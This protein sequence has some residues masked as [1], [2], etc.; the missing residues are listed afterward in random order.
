MTAAMRSLQRDGVTLAYV[1]EGRGAP[2]LLLVHGWVGDHTYLA[3]QF[4]RFQADHRVV[5]V[6]LRGHGA[7]DRPQPAQP[8]TIAGFADDLAW[9]CD[10]LALTAPVVV[11]HS[12]G[13]VV[14]L[15]LAARYPHLPAA[16]VLLDAP[17]VLRPGLLDALRDFSETLRG[18][19]YRERVRRFVA[20]MFLPTDDPE[21]KARIV[22]QM[23]SADAAVLRSAFAEMVAYD[24]VAAAGACRAPL[25]TLSSAVPSSDNARFH[26]L[27]PQ[28]VTGQT[29]GSG[30]FH[31]LEV[32]DQVNAMLDRFLAIS[33]PAHA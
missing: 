14:A 23:A 19:D 11:G 3:P 9:L 5:A 7:S 22:E 12:L 25:L 18:P 21:R 2:P 33:L 24:S 31:Q 30:H 26:K 16:I 8:Y 13:G 17:V 4:A 1:E 29:V 6:D 27:C 15:D 28:L 10:A 20:N 32:P